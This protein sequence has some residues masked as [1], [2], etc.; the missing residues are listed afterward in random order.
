MTGFEPRTSGIGTTE[1]QPLP[2]IYRTF[3]CQNFSIPIRRKSPNKRKKKI[4][5]ELKICQ[6]RKP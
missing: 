3:D 5:E 6:N 1:P 2:K 4:R